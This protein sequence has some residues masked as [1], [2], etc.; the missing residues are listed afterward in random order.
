MARLIDNPMYNAWKTMW[1]R[2]NNNL[3]SRYVHY[4][5]R[6]IQ[7]CSQWDSFENFLKDMGER[8]T[9]K[10][11]IDRID[12]NGNYEPSNCRWATQSEQ[13][14]NNRRTILIIHKGSTLCV[15]DWASKQGIHDTRIL[16][17]ISKGWSIEDALEKPVRAIKR[18]EI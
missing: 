12:N 5:G 16:W 18:R 14:R 17:R 4:G 3:N 13:L 10:H 1:Q 6:G 8:P 15:K 7:V 9:Q 2:C 11:S